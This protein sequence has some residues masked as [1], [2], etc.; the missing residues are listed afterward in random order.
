MGFEAPPDASGAE[1][2]IEKAGL[3]PAYRE[4]LLK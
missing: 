3:E 4:K 1:E 2:I